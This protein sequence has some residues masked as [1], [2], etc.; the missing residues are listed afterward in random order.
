MDPSSV[1]CPNPACPD[2]GQREEANMRIHSQK[3]RRYRWRSA[4]LGKRSPSCWNSS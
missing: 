1:F 3:E 2:K 4:T